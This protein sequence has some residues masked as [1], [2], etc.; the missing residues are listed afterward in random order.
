MSDK[1]K[2]VLAGAQD[3][4]DLNKGFDKYFEALQQL[5]EKDGLFLLFFGKSHGDC[6]KNLDV[7]YMN[8][9]F[10]H[11]TVSLRLAY[12]AADVFVA[13]SVMDGFGKTLAESMACGTPVVCFDAT[14][15]KDIVDHKLNGYKASP[16]E[17]KDLAAGIGWVLS[18]KDRHKG[19]CLKAREKAVE[20]FD[21][22]KV[23]EKYLE[24]YENFIAATKR[25]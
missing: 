6:F 3:L 5:K 12:A 15:P 14:G 16:Y 21:F 11:D 10:L 24:L 23:S 7:E 13:P 25:K 9:G 2:I 4:G 19:L 20:K 18:D 8:L 22:K 17:T 1:K